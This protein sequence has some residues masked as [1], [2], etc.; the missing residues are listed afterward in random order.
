MPENIELQPNPGYESEKVEIKKEKKRELTN[1][2]KLLN[3]ILGKKEDDPLISIINEEQRQKLKEQIDL[4]LGKLTSREREVI[5][6]RYGLGDDGQAHTLEEIGN[7]FGVH[8][9]TIRQNQVR[10]MR[11]L[12]HPSIK[13]FLKQFLD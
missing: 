9:G 12:E 4:V 6:L 7:I 1:Q 3:E 5:K 13:K 8:K 2:E 11:K 10:A